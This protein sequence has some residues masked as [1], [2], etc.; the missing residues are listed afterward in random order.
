MRLEYLRTFLEVVEQGSL[1]YAARALGMSVSTV[2]AHVNAVEE[3]FGERLL[4]RRKSGVELTEKGRIA[5]QEV[6]SILKKLERA[7]QEVATRSALP[8]RIALGNIPGVVLFPEILREYRQLRPDVELT[9]LIKNSS[10][11][12]SLLESS[13][14]DIAVACFIE[15]T[16][17]NESY[18]CTEL[19][20]DRLVLVL[21]EEHPLAEVQK[22]EIREVLRHP[23]VTLPESSGITRYLHAALR[24][25]GI[26]PRKIRSIAEV[27]SVF[28]QLQAVARGLGAAITS[29][30][31]ARSM[32]SGLVV[33]EIADFNAKRH[34]YVVCRRDSA[35]PAKQEFVSFFVQRSRRLLS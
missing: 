30:I 13:E 8:L 6:R 3:F 7:R 26:D 20:P 10:E 5:V 34:L 12:A 14:V 17:D 19:G 28:S 23:L 22:P 33:R 1:L 25:Q 21:N 15:G 4:E 31:A 16:L 27:N 11:C 9:V 24:R 2:S 18:E 35:H 32:N 29:E